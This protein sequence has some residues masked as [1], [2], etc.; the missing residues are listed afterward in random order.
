VIV[1]VEWL[2]CNV[3]A[4]EREEAYRQCVC[5]F[6]CVC[7]RERSVGRAVRFGK[8]SWLEKLSQNLN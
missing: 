7:V 6:V 1:G 4:V 8:P 2:C 5:V 3:L